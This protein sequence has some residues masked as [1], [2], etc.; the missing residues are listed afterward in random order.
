WMI[1]SL[2]FSPQA[3]GFLISRS[4]DGRGWNM[5]V[6]AWESDQDLDFDKP[7]IAC[8]NWQTSPHFG[9]CYLSWAD[10]GT[11][12]LVTQTSQDGGLTWGPS[13]P[14][15]TF[16]NDSL[17]GSQPVVRPDGTL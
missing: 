8:D 13:V 14:S 5:P 4:A 6:V 12:K 9:N 1:V 15:P 7:W 16:G 2:G 10:F 3:N 17:N 11:N